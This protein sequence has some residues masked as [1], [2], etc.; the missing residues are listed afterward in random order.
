MLQFLKVGRQ[1]GPV[2][3]PVCFSL[4]VKTGEI[5]WLSGMPGAGKSVLARMALGLAAPTTGSVRVNGMDPVKASFAERRR[6]RRGVSAVL[7]DSPEVGLAAESWF[8]LGTW[9]AGRSWSASIAAARET[10]VRLGMRELARERFG[11]LGRNQRFTLALARALD[12]KPGLL[13]VD[14]AGAFRKPLPDVLVQDVSR[15]ASEGGAVFIIGE[16][17]E[18]MAMPGSRQERIEPAGELR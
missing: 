1:F 8:A 17:A 16:Q 4:E 12:R 11:S 15:F 14:W 7:D 9:C 10:M 6:L 18:C 13:I 5:A 2:W 3:A